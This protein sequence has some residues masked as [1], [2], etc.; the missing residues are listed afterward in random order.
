[1]SSAPASNT[2]VE[3]APLC[4]SRPKIK[5]KPS[6][7]PSIAAL[8]LFRKK[9]PPPRPS[10]L[11]DPYEVA[12]GIWSTDATARVFGYLDTNDKSVELS[13]KVKRKPVPIRDSLSGCEQAHFVGRTEQCNTEKIKDELEAP[14]QLREKGQD[15]KEIER[16][17]NWFGVRQ[18]TMKTVSKD[19]QLL[20][21]GAN[22]RTGLV[23]P[24]VVGDDSGEC[25]GGDYVAGAKVRSADPSLGK[26]ACSGM[27]KQDSLGWSLVESPLFS[28]IAQS[29]SEMS[30]TICQE[31]LEDRLLVDMPSVNDPNSKN[32]TNEQIKQYQE[33]IA[34]VHKRGGGSIAMLDPD[35]LPSPRERTPVGPSTPPMK[36]RKIRRKEIGSGAVRY[37][38]SSDT[39]IINANNRASSLP[40]P[41]KDIMERQEVRIVTPS[42]TPKGSSF[43]SSA[44]VGNAKGKTGAFLGR[45]SR[46]T[47]IQTVS[48]T[49]SQPYLNSGQAHQNHQKGSESGQ[50]STESEPPV[51]SRTLSQ[52]IHRLQLPNPSPFANLETSAHRPPVQLRPRDLGQQRRA[53]EN[54]C[55]T[56]FTTTSTKGVEWDQRPKLRRQDEKDVVQRVNHL[57][58]K[59]E[60]PLEGYHHIRTPRNKLF[61]PEDFLVDA[62]H[63][64]GSVPGGRSQAIGSPKKAD[65]AK[66]P[67]NT[68]CQRKTQMH[69][70][71]FRQ[72]PCEDWPRCLASPNHTIQI[73]GRES[74]NVAQESI[75]R[76]RG[77]D[78]YTPAIGHRGNHCDQYRRIPL[79]R[80]QPTSDNLEQA[81]LPAELTD[82]SESRVW[83]GEQWA[84]V[85][86]EWESERPDLSALMLEETM[87]QSRSP[88]KT[89]AD[90]NSWLYSREAL[91]E[92]LVTQSLIQQPFSQMMCHFVRTLHHASLALNTLGMA[93]AT[94]QDQLR[95]MK[96]LALAALYLLLLSKSLMDLRGV[97]IFA[98]KALYCAWHPMQ[99][100]LR[101]LR[102]CVIG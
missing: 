55:S 93:N 64:S 73:L 88:S 15:E 71:C 34:R 11:V 43:E 38:N 60:Q 91:A 26:R 56:T 85:E 59:Y 75:Q 28:P 81:T 24:F 80:L 4:T 87:E 82:R 57:S 68:R 40:R 23:S 33:R 31:Q 7:F 94:T 16:G 74:V 76:K 102:W 84:E 79:A 99:T 66:N 58:P 3:A 39:V 1:M 36:L 27:W 19:D 35:T 8:N 30:R 46:S 77:G 97:L 22:P 13:Q 9:L 21:R 54:A 18:R 37:R 45:E 51:V 32:M 50:S 65:R 52:C 25:L 92:P 83:F 53:V 70:E 17:N 101:I 86:R 100:F 98:C 49:H 29:M 90:M 10:S 96:D 95:A 20:E 6:S 47:C 12:P 72:P 69:A 67:V 89:A 61:L 78:G 2:S 14:S 62:I 41:R 48:A 42:N 63:T 5:G 44:D